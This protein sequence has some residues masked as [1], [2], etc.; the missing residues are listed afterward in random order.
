MLLEVLFCCFTESSAV[1]GPM[2]EEEGEGEASRGLMPILGQ[3][4]TPMD[5]NNMLQ[6]VQSGCNGHWSLV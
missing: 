6:Q 2:R 1:T 5:M 4:R 3:A